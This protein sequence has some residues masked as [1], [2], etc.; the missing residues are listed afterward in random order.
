MHDSLRSVSIVGI[1]QIPVQK[2]SGASLREMGA[3]AVR[4]AM[5]NAGVETVNGLFVGNMLSDELQGQKHLATLIASAAGLRGIEALQV[6]AATAT[7]AAAL[8]MAYFA[9]A[10]GEARLAIALGVEK[11]SGGGAT[12]ALAKALDAETEVPTGAT[13]LGMNA[14][15]MRMYMEKYG[16]SVDDFNGFSLNAHANARTNPYALFKDLHVTGEMISQSRVVVP[17]LRVF[18][19]SPVCDGAAAVVLTRSSEARAYTDQPVKILSSS[20]ATDW[21]RVEDR[22][23]PLHLYAAAR[24]AHDACRKA[25]VHRNDI[26][27]FEV[28]DAFSIMACLALE[29]VGFAER[30]QGWRLAAEQKIALDGPLPLSTF[31]GLKARGHPV[32]AT[33]IYQTC[34]IVQQLMGR[35]GANQVRDARLAMLLSVGGAASTALTHIFGV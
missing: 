27:L 17:P 32:G 20:V 13:L 28:H 24:S 3:Q 10:S 31:G 9:V 7:G 19:A 35:A 2:A 33:A 29:A 15:L 16:V 23:D 22:P 25:N 12:E 34:E 14:R 6:E 1:G 26:D 30:G 21:F 8:R 4:L 18:D 5:Q 11:M